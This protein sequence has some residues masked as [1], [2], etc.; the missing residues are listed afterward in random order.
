MSENLQ[1]FLAAPRCV[2]QNCPS[3]KMECAR[4]KCILE[5]RKF[6]AALDKECKKNIAVHEANLTKYSVQL[7]AARDASEKKMAKRL[8]SLSEEYLEM[9][10]S[11]ATLTTE[12]E[13]MIWFAKY[14][15]V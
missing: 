15:M 1:A 8:V 10:R 9:Y 2:A 3:K 12:K 14:F 6:F 5:I 13:K 7:A 11:Y 4:N